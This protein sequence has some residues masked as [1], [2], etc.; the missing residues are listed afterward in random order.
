[1]H[2]L[3]DAYETELA[4]LRAQNK[5]SLYRSENLKQ[6]LS[7]LASEMSSKAKETHALQD[8]VTLLREELHEN[9]QE[10][11]KLGT[12]V[13]SIKHQRTAIEAKCNKMERDLIQFKD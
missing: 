6:E 7:K 11:K 3:E 4:E 5:Q 2:E 10:R 12:F 8:K 13:D 1:M 9:N